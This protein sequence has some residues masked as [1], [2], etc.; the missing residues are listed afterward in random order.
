MD[1]QTS[2]L[3]RLQMTPYVWTLRISICSRPAVTALQQNKTM[4]SIEYKYLKI[5][6]KN[7]STI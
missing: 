7:Q 5:Y 1:L 3:E 4:I 6:N 2:W